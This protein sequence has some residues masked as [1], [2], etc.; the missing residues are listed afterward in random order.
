MTPVSTSPPPPVETPEPEAKK[1]LFGAR[2]PNR[3]TSAVRLDA[4]EKAQIVKLDRENLGTGQIAH[5]IGRPPQTVSGYLRRHRSTVTEARQYFESKAEQLARRVVK[6]AD[7]DQSID[8]LDRIDVIP[9]K[10]HATGVQFNVVIG[11]PGQT[12]PVPSER[13]LREV[14]RAPIS[15]GVGWLK[16][17]KLL[18]P[19]DTVNAVPVRQRKEKRP[20]GLHKKPKK[21]KK[22]K[23]SK[24]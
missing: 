9:K 23:E 7:V 4:E 12:I 21:G 19:G 2:A 11:M 14:E 5:A 16:E 18:E 3:T 13:L 8:V 6:H 1:K 10:E 20:M 17:Q 15:E 22:R 24:Y